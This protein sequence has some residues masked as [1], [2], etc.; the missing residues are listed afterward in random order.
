M[1]HGYDLQGRRKLGGGRVA[2]HYKGWPIAAAWLVEALVLIAV[3]RAAGR[4]GALDAYCEACDAPTRRHFAHVPTPPEHVAR[5]RAA[6]SADDLAALQRSAT[7]E[8]PTV[9]YHLDQCPRCDRGWL[10]VTVK[11]DPKAPREVIHREVALPPE[12]AKALRG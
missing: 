9:I 4:G 5:L 3:G 6:A 2:L 7:P 11:A 12:R 10:S 8:A 1:E